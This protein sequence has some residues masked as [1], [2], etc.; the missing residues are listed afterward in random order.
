MRFLDAHS[1]FQLFTP[2]DKGHVP[3][4]GDARRSTGY[5][6]LEGS[7]ATGESKDSVGR[8]SA[9]GCFGS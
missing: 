8:F 4:G 2:K 9:R 3:A 5:I 1:I 7:E 6:C